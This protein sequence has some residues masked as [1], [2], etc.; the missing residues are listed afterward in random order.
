MLTNWGRLTTLACAQ[1]IQSRIADAFDDPGSPIRVRIGVHT[2]EV[3]AHADDFFGHAVNYA[4]RVAGEA[5]G[6]EILVSALVHQLTF[7]TGPLAFEAP[8]TVELKGVE[9]PV[10][11]Y[12]LTA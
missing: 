3:V 7:Q 4:A 12:P 10:A 11:V 9:G 8:R 1:S 5:R 2:G 6:G